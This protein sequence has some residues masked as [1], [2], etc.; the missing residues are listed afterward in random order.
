VREFFLAHKQRIYDRLEEC[1]LI[2]S[3]AVSNA[4]M[5]FFAES[6]PIINGI[7]QVGSTR[8]ELNTAT[9]WVRQNWEGSEAQPRIVLSALLFRYVTTEGA[10][11]FLHGPDQNKRDRWTNIKER[12]ARLL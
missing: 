1:D 5:L 4:D 8:K 3:E 2:A 7:V 6:L 10:K 12:V 9:E 11:E